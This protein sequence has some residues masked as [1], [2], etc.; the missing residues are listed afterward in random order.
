MAEVLMKLFCCFVLALCSVS[1][2]AGCGPMK[3]SQQLPTSTEPSGDE[4][5]PQTK[6][7]EEE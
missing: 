4:D 3:G 6:P 5:E 2:L 1:M 7:R